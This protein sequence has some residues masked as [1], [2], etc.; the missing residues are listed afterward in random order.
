[1]PYT[2]GV[3][4]PGLQRPSQNKSLGRR[5]TERCPLRLVRR[6]RGRRS[7]R[8][9]T[10][11]DLHRRDP[12][13]ST[14]W[15]G[16][17]NDGFHRGA[18]LQA[19]RVPNSDRVILQAIAPAEEG[20]ELYIEYG[21]D[22]WQGHYFELPEAVQL[23]AA[24]HYDLTALHGVCYTP[25]QRSLAV[26]Q[27]TLHKR[28]T[29]WEAGPGTTARTRRT[30]STPQPPRI[31]APHR[32]SP[33]AAMGSDGV[34]HTPTNP[35]AIL[36]S[37]RRNP[38]SSTEP[39]APRPSTPVPPDSPLTP[40]GHTDLA[41]PNHA[42]VPTPPHSML[43]LDTSTSPLP[44]DDRA[45]DTLAPR[46]PDLDHSTTGRAYQHVTWSSALHSSQIAG[47]LQI[48]WGDSDDTNAALA[49]YLE[50]GPP[51]LGQ[52]F[53]EATRHASPFSFRYWRRTT[54]PPDPWFHRGP[55]EGIVT[56][57]MMKARA[58]SGSRNPEIHGT[59]TLTDPNDQQA[60]IEHCVALGRT[61]STGDATGLLGPAQDLTPTALHALRDPALPYSCFIRNPSQ[62]NTATGVLALCHSDSR[63]PHHTN[64][65]WADLQVISGDPNYCHHSPDGYAPLTVCAPS[66]ETER[67]RWGIHSLCQST[68][69]AY[70]QR[71]QGPPPPVWKRG[72]NK[73]G[74]PA[75]VPTP[76]P[77]TTHLGPDRPPPLPGPSG[78]PPH[79]GLPECS[80]WKHGQWTHATLQA[81]TGESAG[82]YFRST[83]YTPALRTSRLP[84]STPMGSRRLS[85][86]NS[87]GSKH[88]RPLTCSY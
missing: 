2:G 62:H 56:D 47:C 18:H 13:I 69:E 82:P 60:L 61:D 81:L 76:N 59:L 53:A 65:T 42:S 5:P 46:V 12:D 52:L 27:G 37:H 6:Q 36:T 28:G 86:R 15:G 79:N 72:R 38:N 39:P 14:S 4:G 1:M 10:H 24:A 31:P 17:V 58:A 40:Q 8:M 64:F 30:R 67:I 16:R 51:D 68:V 63:L 35:P 19:T 71:T 41:G 88:G 78:P 34:T 43:N 70:L 74:L 9:R 48:A 50:P 29:Q 54:G 80:G 11:T 77:S 23:E 7:R 87:S 55:L 45:A 84:H 20:D 57:Y 26:Q 22:Y 66:N 73:T 83:E 32:P 44:Q 3:Y 75:F 85:L 33:L 25:A 21:P 49:Q